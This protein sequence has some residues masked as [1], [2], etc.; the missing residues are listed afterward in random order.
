M[1]LDELKNLNLRDPRILMRLIL[2]FLL[3]GNLIAFYF[4]LYPLGGSPE[5]LDQQLQAL[6][7]QASAQ[8]KSLDRLRML[9]TKVEGAREQAGG[10]ELANFTDRR[11][12]YSTLVNEITQAAETAGIKLKDHALQ[13]EEIEGSETLGMITVNANYE[14]TYGDLLNFV[15]RLD[16]SERFVIID[17]LAATPQQGSNQLNVT[18]KMNLF[19][20]NTADAQLPRPTPK[21]S[22]APTAEAAE[23]PPS[24]ATP[25]DAPP[26]RAPQT[27]GAAPAGATPTRTPLTGSPVLGTPP[28]SSPPPGSRMLGTPPTSS[29]LPGSRVLGTPPTSSPLPGGQPKGAKL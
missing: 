27:T 13:N 11:V 24:T 22:A 25:A 7:S 18:M 29:P 19:V 16:R 23:L 5:E 10:F 20:R 17:S 14:G 8:R 4:V 1:N 3:L 9:T 2:G 28:A 15:N 6:V 12:V 26:T 21:G